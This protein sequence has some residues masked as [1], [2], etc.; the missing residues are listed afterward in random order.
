ML[1]LLVMLMTTRHI[2]L[3]KIYTASLFKWYSDNQ[4]KANPDRCHFL[5]TE[6]CKKEIKIIGNIIEN[7]RCKYY[8]E[9]Q[10]ERVR[11]LQSL[12]WIP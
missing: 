4:L 7:N 9:L 12:I 1:T 5:I 10:I 3:E 6:T 11:Y 2:L 8:W